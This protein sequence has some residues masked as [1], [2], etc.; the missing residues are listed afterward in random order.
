MRISSALLLMLA[1]CSQQAPAVAEGEEHIACALAGAAGFAPDCAV[2]RVTKDGALTLVVRH[3]DGGFRR[4][5][6]L[7]DGRGLAVSDG[8][9]QAQV[10]LAGDALEVTVGTDRY[11]FP[12]TTKGDAAGK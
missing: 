9:E 6:V 10:A 5:D 3:P 7:K 11:R 2:E 8:A 1:G 4:F 12:A